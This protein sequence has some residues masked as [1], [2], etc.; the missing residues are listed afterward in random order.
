VNGYFPLYAFRLL[1]FA[2]LFSKFQEL[3]NESQPAGILPCWDRPV[4]AQ[5]SSSVGCLS[6]LRKHFYDQTKLLDHLLCSQVAWVATDTHIRVRIAYC[7]DANVHIGALCP[8]F[9]L[10]QSSPKKTPNI[11]CDGVVIDGSTCHYGHVPVNILI[12]MVVSSSS[13]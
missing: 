1:P 11:A 4:I 9:F 5:L 2:S 7:G 12:T 3:L 6:I 10:P 8:A 13:N